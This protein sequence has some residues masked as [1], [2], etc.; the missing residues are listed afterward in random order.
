MT[1]QEENNKLMES[2]IFRKFFT[3]NYSEGLPN[4]EFFVTSNCDLKCEYCYIHNFKNELYPPEVNKPD[5]ILHNLKVMLDYIYDNEFMCTLDLFSGELFSQEIGYQTLD[6]IYQYAVKKPNVIRTILIPTNMNFIHSKEKTARLED[7]L[8]KF[9]SILV[10]I[11][12]SCSFDG[13]YLLENRAFA[14][15]KEI[16]DEEYYDNLFKFIKKHKA[17][18]HPMVS[19]N[20]IEK[21]PQN[22]DWFI[23]KIHQYD[24]KNYKNMFIE[25]MML[26][27][28]NDNWDTK[29][30]NSLLKFY[31]HLFDKLINRF[32]GKEG[33]VDAVYNTKNGTFFQYCNIKLNYEQSNNK[34]ISCA[35]QN[36]LHIRLGD[37]AIIPCHRLGYEELLLGKIKIENDKVSGIE[38]INPSL[39]LTKNMVQSTCLPKC[40]KCEFNDICMKGCLGA[41]YEISKDLFYP[42]ESVCNMLKAKYNY[43]INKHKELGLFDIMFNKLDNNSVEFF[44]KLLNNA[45]GK[46]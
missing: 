6:M 41:Q 45:E 39:F 20:G 8:E 5:I 2:Y 11:H 30:I 18:L 12:L 42:L 36:A 40:A 33:F 13:P 26:E 4:I 23:Q 46:K 25:P 10:P 24:L 37:L 44:K 7:I 21:W 19:A 16:R 27:V 32:G 38:A 31:D 29:S 22:Y 15:N 9:S 35:I 1:Y 3:K 14:N 34:K 43:L 17:G 28:R